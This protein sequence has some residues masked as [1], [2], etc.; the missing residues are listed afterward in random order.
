MGFVVLSAYLVV[1]LLKRSWSWLLQSSVSMRT[2]SNTKVR[3]SSGR[4]EMR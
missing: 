2:P 1:A 4:S 3:I